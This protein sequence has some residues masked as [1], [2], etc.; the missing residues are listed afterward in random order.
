MYSAKR[1]FFPC[2][3]THA[4]IKHAAA[5]RSVCLEKVPRITERNNKGKIDQVLYSGLEKKQHESELHPQNS[6]LFF[7]HLCNNL[8]KC[9]Q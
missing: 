8:G 3:Y 5:V 2:F 4:L 6:D 1:F 9:L 7:W